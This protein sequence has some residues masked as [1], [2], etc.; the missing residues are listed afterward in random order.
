MEIWTDDTVNYLQPFIGLAK[1]Y[2]KRRNLEEWSVEI[3]L[4]ID[5]H[6]KFRKY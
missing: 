4:M 3:E 1:E 2:L 5:L 6:R